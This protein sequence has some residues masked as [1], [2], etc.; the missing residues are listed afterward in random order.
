MPW[1]HAA[2]VSHAAR[3]ASCVSPRRSVSPGPNP[4]RPRFGG[5]GGRGL[6]G[7][8][9]DR[10]R[11]PE[12]RNRPMDLTDGSTWA[13]LYFISEWVIRLGMVVV[14]PFRRSPAAAKAWLLLG[15]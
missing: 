10:R 14:V 6:A 9:N 1:R 11:R 12:T 7:S 2:C 5:E 4:P 13:V 8:G 15:L 3:H